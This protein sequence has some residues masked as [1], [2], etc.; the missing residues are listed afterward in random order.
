MAITGPEVTA[1]TSLKWELFLGM[2]PMLEDFYGKEVASS[3]YL[4][5]GYYSIHKLVW[6]PGT[7]RKL[8]Q[9]G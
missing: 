4:L 6:R 3:E 5:K 7:T 2:M 8:N 9:Q 1:L